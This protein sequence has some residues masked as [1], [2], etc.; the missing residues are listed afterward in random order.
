M[1]FEVTLM[2]ELLLIWGGQGADTRRLAARPKRIKQWYL[3]SQQAHNANLVAL[4]YS[5]HRQ[6][7]KP[8]DFGTVPLRLE[9]PSADA[10]LPRIL[11]HPRQI[12]HAKPAVETTHDRPKH[13]Q[14]T[15]ACGDADASE[16][17]HWLRKYAHELASTCIVA[18][19][20]KALPDGSVLDPDSLKGWR[21]AW[22]LVVVI[23]WSYTRKTAA[24]GTLRLWLAQAL[25]LARH[26]AANR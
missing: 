9:I 2:N 21:W 6:N 23:G 5:L 20:L 24:L 25:A 10:L 14:A 8:G 12:R 19:G 4:I 7:N 26:Y 3:T 16:E 22:Q 11:A 17:T 18:V 1:Y 15:L 13:A